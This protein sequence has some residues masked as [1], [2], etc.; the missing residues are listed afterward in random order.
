MSA[1]NPDC[2]F[3]TELDIGMVLCALF[4]QG[5]RAVARHPAVFRNLRKSPRTNNTVLL[6][7]VPHAHH[8]LPGPHS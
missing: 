5:E 4:L 6:E 1:R 3:E 7:S 2:N 8:L